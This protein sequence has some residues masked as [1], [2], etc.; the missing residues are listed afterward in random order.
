M[1]CFNTES[2]FT[3]GDGLGIF[4]SCHCYLLHPVFKCIV[5]KYC[6]SY[7]WPDPLSLFFFVYRLVN[8]LS[9][10]ILIVF[11]LYGKMELPKTFHIVN[12]F[13]MLWKSKH[14]QGPGNIR[15]SGAQTVSICSQLT[16]KHEGWSHLCI[17][18]HEGD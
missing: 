5:F 8:I 1:Q 14:L 13:I 11:S 7:S 15:K 18:L 6:L 17:I 16:N 12:A 10:V 2:R 4:F 9:M 3:W